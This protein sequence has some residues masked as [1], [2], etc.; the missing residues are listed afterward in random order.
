MNSNKVLKNEKLVKIH[1][2][3]QILSGP[4]L[5]FWY[6]HSGA[7]TLSIKTLSIT[8]ISIKTLSM[9]GLC[10][11]LSISDSAWQCSA[12]LFSVSLYY[13]A[14]CRY[15]ECHYAECH[16]AEC[17]GAKNGQNS[18]KYGCLHITMAFKHLAS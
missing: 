10:V 2:F 17:R 18:G 1:K 9:N 15:D 16:C 13:Y 3:K 8:T 4:K 12:I 6:G 5:L 11:T 14:E 7:T